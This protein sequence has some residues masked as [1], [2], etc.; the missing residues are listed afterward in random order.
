[1]ISN[2][3]EMAE[4]LRA[5]DNY[6]VITHYRPDG[7]A[8]GSALAMV[9][10]LKSMGK[11]AFPVCDDEVTP[12]YRF[13]D[14]WEKFTNEEKGLP[15]VPETALGVDVSNEERMGKSTALFNSCKYRAVIDHHESNI[16]FAPVTLLDSKAVAA[17]QIIVKLANVLGIKI[18]KP[19]AEQLYTAIATDSGNFSFKDTNAESFS[20]TAELLEAGVDVETLTRR[21][22]RERSYAQ[23]RLLALALNQIQL[24]SD[25]RVAGIMITDE[26]FQESGAARPDSHPIVNYLNEIRGV[27]VGFTAEQLPDHVKISFRAGNGTDVAALAERFDGGGHIAAAGGRIPGGILEKEFSNIMRVSEE[28]LREMDAA[29]RA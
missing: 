12:K 2:I 28:Y 8:F 11:N 1:M 18:D 9:R 20:L 14:G 6:A 13:L 21:L 25:G 4:F 27:C 7:D 15:Y 10:I 16:G 24:S 26:M 22:F 3:N 23:T 5:H 19:L 17:G 29:K